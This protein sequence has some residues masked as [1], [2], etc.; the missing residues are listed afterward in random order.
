MTDGRRINVAEIRDYDR[1]LRGNISLTI[2]MRDGSCF[3]YSD[4]TVEDLDRAIIDLKGYGGEASKI[5]IVE[6]LWKKTAESATK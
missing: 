6:P 4:I 2:H 5:V 3:N 1:N